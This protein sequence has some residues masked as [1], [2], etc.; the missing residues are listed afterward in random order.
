[1]F[2]PT[3]I[4]IE[5]KDFSERLI[6]EKALGRGSITVKTSQQLG[7]YLAV[8][9][10]EGIFHLKYVK[11]WEEKGKQLITYQVTRPY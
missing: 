9:S 1:M 11:A 4:T 2:K 3:N 7:L 5:L 10:S 6:L 8:D